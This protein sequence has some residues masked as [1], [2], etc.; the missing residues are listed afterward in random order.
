MPHHAADAAAAAT[1]LCY[2]EPKLS[3]FTQRFLNQL[4]S[5]TAQPGFF[6]LGT[7]V[8]YSASVQQLLEAF[9][10]LLFFL[11]LDLSPFFHAV[12]ASMMHIAQIMF[13][14]V[15]Y[16]KFIYSEKA[17]KFCEIFT[18]LLSYVV[19]VKSKVKILQNFVAFLEYMNFK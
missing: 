4:Q 3:S 16:V 15:R 19:P 1:R 2:T 12:L 7:P 13:K 18:L 8:Q 11:R 14:N 9:F 6:S 17:T 10:F 5:P